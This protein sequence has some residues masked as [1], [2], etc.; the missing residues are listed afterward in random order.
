MAVVQ[1]TTEELA[2][3]DEEEAIA[4]RGKR[5]IGDGLQWRDEVEGGHPGLLFIGAEG[6]GGE[7]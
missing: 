6:H 3:G 5:K 2:A 7:R 4:A 1:S